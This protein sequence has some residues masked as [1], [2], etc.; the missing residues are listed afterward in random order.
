MLHCKTNFKRR[1]QQEYKKGRHQRIRPRPAPFWM[2]QVSK[3]K[4][5]Q[6]KLSP[7]T[8]QYR[9]SRT[10]SLCSSKRG[11]PRRPCLQAQPTLNSHHQLLACF[12]DHRWAERSAACRSSTRLPISPRRSPT[13]FLHSLCL[14]MTP[15][16]GSDHI[17][18]I[19]KSWRC[20]HSVMKYTTWARIAARRLEAISSSKVLQRQCSATKLV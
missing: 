14:L 1:S 15:S 5:Q 9:S 2:K 10:N 18:M 12:G 20:K 3:E 17:W 19:S 7:L 16:N 13:A 11:R 4:Q 6:H 8:C